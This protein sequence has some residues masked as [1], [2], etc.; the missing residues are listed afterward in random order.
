MLPRHHS[1]A[2]RAQA[3]PLLHPSFSTGNFHQLLVFASLSSLPDIPDPKPLSFFPVVVCCCEARTGVNTAPGNGF[4]PHT[5]SEQ[6]R[7]WTGG[8]RQ[9]LDEA[10]AH[11]CNCQ[12]VCV[13]P[14][15]M[16]C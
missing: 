8:V 16:T 11:E 15:V 9:V 14:S 1:A 2:E 3:L 4:E 12:N 6:V 13:P 5:V 10:S 7:F